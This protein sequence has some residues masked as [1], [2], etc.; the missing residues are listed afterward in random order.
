M[1]GNEGFELTDDLNPFHFSVEDP[2]D[3]GASECDVS[4]RSM[5]AEFL[6]AQ[7]IAHAPA[8]PF[9]EIEFPVS[10]LSGQNANTQRALRARKDSH[11]RRDALSVFSLRKTVQHFGQFTIPSQT[12]R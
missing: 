7:C 4:V 10:L 5:R 3:D 2:Q 9:D 12:T 1:L 8:R 6:I 11:G